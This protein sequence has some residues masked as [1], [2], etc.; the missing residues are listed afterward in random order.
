MVVEIEYADMGLATD[1]FLEKFLQKEG[2]ETTAGEEL[3]QPALA[4]FTISK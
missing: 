3:L 1:F 2:C 4:H